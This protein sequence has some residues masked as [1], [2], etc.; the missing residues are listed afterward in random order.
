MI[1]AFRLWFSRNHFLLER[2]GITF[3]LSP[4]S[5]GL[6]KNGIS[7]V[8]KSDRVEVTIE[9][10]ETGESEFYFLNWEAI[11]R[12]PNASVVVTHYDFTPVEELYAA[13]DQLVNQMSPVLI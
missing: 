9:L 11:E 5:T 10:W 8:L 3:D 4:S 7:A 1:E 2:D 6:P 13:L 12:D